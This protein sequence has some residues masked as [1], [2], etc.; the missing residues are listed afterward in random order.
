MLNIITR[1][2]LQNKHEW[3]QGQCEHNKL[4]KPPTN[5]HGVEIPYFVTGDNDYRL[6][7]KLMTD[8]RWMKSP[9]YLL[10]SGTFLYLYT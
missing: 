10:D 5:S 6:L 8:K 9:K 4:T 2:V 7:Q 3:Y 1:R